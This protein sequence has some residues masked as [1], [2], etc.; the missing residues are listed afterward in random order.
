[1]INKN[2]PLQP[3]KAVG[4]GT[5]QHTTTKEAPSSRL[6]AA[7]SLQKPA[8]KTT[9]AV[10]Q[11]ES[12]SPSLVS[13]PA[14]RPNLLSATGRSRSI[15]FHNSILVSSESQSARL[16]SFSSSKGPSAEAVS[17]LV[18]EDDQSK[19]AL[20]LGNKPAKMPSTIIIESNSD[21]SS[22]KKSAISDEI[23]HFSDEE[24]PENKPTTAARGFAIPEGSKPMQNKELLAIQSKLEDIYL[25]MQ[26]TQGSMYSFLDAANA[27]TQNLAGNIAGGDKALLD[28]I[29][30]LQKK[31]F[32]LNL[33]Y[34]LSTQT[35]R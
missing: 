29:K 6:F 7:P 32:G 34:T 30:E 18:S 23:I 13:S 27:L 4:P 8:V 16:Q 33:A 24:E 12:K 31:I 11:E 15:G 26:N 14:S 17:R 9:A 1:M 25:Q 20:C 2:T 19:V 5:S 22:E 35:H 21:V 3:S 28:N 10:K